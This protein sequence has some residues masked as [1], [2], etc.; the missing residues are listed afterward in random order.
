MN[1]I[2]N[3]AYLT[4]MSGQRGSDCDATHGVWGAQ[5]AIAGEGCL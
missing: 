1:D 5:V 3:D 2:T 4:N